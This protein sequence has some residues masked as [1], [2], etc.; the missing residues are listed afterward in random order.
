MG[1]P[2]F[3]AP[4]QW[5]SPSAASP[6][7]DIYSAGVSLYYLLSLGALPVDD[8]KPLDQINPSVPPSLQEVVEGCLARRPSERWPSAA[9]LEKRLAA[10]KG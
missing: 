8:Y 7:S 10:L 9:A 6:Q 5:E 2:A 1:T 3:T 4:E